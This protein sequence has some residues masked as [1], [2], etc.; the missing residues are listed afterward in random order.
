MPDAYDDGVRLL[1]RRS[2]TRRE[3]I[4]RLLERGHGAEEVEDAVGR[5]TAGSAI[6][7]RAL[8]RHWIGSQAAARGRGRSRALAELVARGVPEDV[9][10]SAWAEAV[11]DGAIDEDAALARAV[12]RRLG[13]PPGRN[14]LGR[15]ARVY[16]ALL[17]E[18]FGREQVEAA[19]VPY[20]F[21]RTDA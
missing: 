20:G 2:L 6:D 17:D 15:L 9:A 7:D 3:V 8:A 4:E 13:P 16:N 5:L 11:E 14:G 19:L 18:G 1:R 21:Q 12:R 10:V